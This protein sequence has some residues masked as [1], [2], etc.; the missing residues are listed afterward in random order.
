MATSTNVQTKA[1][2][3]T[4]DHALKE[5]WVQFADIS[6]NSSDRYH[7]VLNGTGYV[8]SAT[9]FIAWRKGFPD[10]IYEFNIASLEPK[11]IGCLPFALA[12]IAHII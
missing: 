7:F 9:A 1:A 4:D 6:L 3:H 8:P 10:P 11:D 5:I 2:I 12:P